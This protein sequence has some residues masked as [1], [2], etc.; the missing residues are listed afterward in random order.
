[1]SAHG[2]VHA[3]RGVAAVED[4]I[5]CDA[6]LGVV[7]DGRILAVSVGVYVNFSGIV[8]DECAVGAV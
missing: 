5:V 1:L 3:Q 8:P 4:S 6:Q 7:D 2:V